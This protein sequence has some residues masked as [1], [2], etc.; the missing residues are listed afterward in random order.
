MGPYA[1]FS[2]GDSNDA[3]SVPRKG[4]NLEYSDETPS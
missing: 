4:H 3:Q 1:A 2:A